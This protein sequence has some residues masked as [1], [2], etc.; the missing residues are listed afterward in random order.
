[1]LAKAER[2]AATPLLPGRRVLGNLIAKVDRVLREEPEALRPRDL[3]G[4]PGGLVLLPDLPT[5]LVPD[6][7]ARPAFL[8]QVLGW[9]AGGRRVADLLA[10]GEVN[11]VCLGDVLHSEWGEAATR[12]ALAFGEYASGWARHAAMDEEM[13]L[14]LGAVRIILE[15]KLAFPDRF[16][17]LKGNHD[18]LA[19]E[20]GRGDHP[21][22][23][24]A[25]EGEMGA[26]WFTAA[27]GEELLAEYRR[28]E[29]DLPL[30]VQGRR[31]IASHGE[32]AFAME[33]RDVIEY[34][35]R[36]DV[37][38]ALIW[39]PNDGAEAF[40]VQRGL[41]AFLGEGAEGSLWFG[42]HRPVD[43]GFALR[44][45]GRYVQFHNPG[46]RQFLFLLPGRN[47]DPGRD[48]VVLK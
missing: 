46:R 9:T 42:G 25:A 7:H 47:P 24:F 20:E 27:Y 38:E 43:G 31:F 41:E 18:N 2:I 29:L 15:T 10:A 39:T 48:L 21:F 13:A 12:W 6:L 16:H 8:A 33:P 34:R 23:K 17:Y 44:A 14:A 11:L 40:S 45:G 26:S 36:P 28:L 35:S 32:P 5:I 19:N 1:L 37:V 3:S 22:Y 4:L 30:V